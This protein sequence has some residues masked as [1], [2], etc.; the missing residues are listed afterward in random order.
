MLPV[1]TYRE[2][3][4]WGFYVA[5]QDIHR[6]RQ[7]VYEHEG[8]ISSLEAWRDNLQARHAST[9]TWIFGVIATVISGATLVLN[10]WL[11]GVRP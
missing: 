4:L 8:R 11:A 2:R 9:P 10:L 7:Q 3:F 5:E 1:D 6:L